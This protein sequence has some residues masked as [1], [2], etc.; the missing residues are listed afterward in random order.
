VPRAETKY[1]AGTL[2]KL[3]GVIDKKVCMCTCGVNTCLR[4]YVLECV[5]MLLCLF[6]LEC[7]FEY[8]GTVCAAFFCFCIRFRASPPFS[9]DSQR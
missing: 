8:V 9:I 5:R 6:V 3:F 1:K 2:G 4:V 7:L